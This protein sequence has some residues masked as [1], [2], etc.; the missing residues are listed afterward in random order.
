MYSLAPVAATPAFPSY[1]LR[2]TIPRGIAIPPG[3]TCSTCETNRPL[4]SRSCWADDDVDV[5]CCCGVRAA[6]CAL[7]SLHPAAYRPS[8]IAMSASLLM[9]PPVVGGGWWTS[10]GVPLPSTH[11]P[12]PAT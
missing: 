2:S 7:E 9:A 12:L 11:Y 5:V 6:V 10:G 1:G 4:E 8:G 3:C